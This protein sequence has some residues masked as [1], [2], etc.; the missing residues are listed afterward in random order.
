MLGPPG[1][2]D[3][4]LCGTG[5]TSRV[6]RAVEVRSGH[7]VALKRLHRQLL[8]SEEARARLKREFEALSRLRHPGLVAV[9]DVLVWQ[10][11]PTVVMDFIAGE[12]LDRRIAEQGPVSGAF[13]TQLAIALFEMLSAAHGAGIVHRDVKPQ[14]VRIAEDGRFHL[15]DFGSA[16]FDAASQLTAA[17]TSVGTPDY[18]APELFAGSVYDPRVDIYG[19]GAT[20][21]KALTG[22]APQ[23]ADSLTELAYRRTRE[24]VPPVRSLRPDVPQALAQVVDRCLQ[25]A[26]SDRFSSCALA[27]WALQHPQAELSFQDRRRAHP[28]C[29]HCARPIPPASAICPQCG[30]DH[31]FAYSPGS[32]H[33]ELHNVKDPER[34]ARWWS[35][36]FPERTEADHITHLCERLSALDEDSQRLLSFI[37][38]HEARRVADELEAEGVQCEVLEDQGTTGWR[39]YALSLALFMVGLVG[40]GHGLLGAEVAWHHAL[41]LALPSAG[42][43]VLER[44]LAVARGAQGLLSS[45]RYPAAIV[46][47]LRAGLT[48]GS[49]GLLGA[50]VLAPTVGAALSGAGAVGAGAAVGALVVPLGVAGV[51]GAAAA[52]V[53]WT[54]G[55]RRR[56]LPATSVPEPSALRMLRQAFSVPRALVSG[57]LRTETAVLLTASV[58]ALVPAEMLALD[59]VR[60]AVPA[61]GSLVPSLTSAPAIAPSLP[62]PV[63]SLPVSPGPVAGPTPGLTP[64]PELPGPTAPTSGPHP[65]P[66]A[67]TPT[68]GPQLN[69]PPWAVGLAGLF[70]LSSL[71]LIAYILARR[72]RVVRE[73][74]RIEARL[75]GFELGPGRSPPVQRR[76]GALGAADALASLPGHDRFLIG[77]RARAADLAHCLDEEGADRLA[78]LLARTVA[79]PSRPEVGPLD[80]IRPTDPD[81][82]LRFEF[83]ALEGELEASAAAAWWQRLSEDDS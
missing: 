60:Q 7:P 45:G 40:V 11:D 42:A 59:A 18:M 39:L 31:P 37:D 15:L 56:A 64:G 72:R 16:R 74:G 29:L 28:P 55:F 48:L 58:L 50:G 43:L 81:Q 76:P 79:D 53:A 63:T 22:G 67:A 21:Y 32:H 1:Y 69:L 5:A 13:A 3:V 62:V 68:T 80:T 25:R 34:L 35:E 61:L 54:A 20:L 57:R 17:G 77:A 14:N 6:F 19:V 33:V 4:A 70:G 10:G 83:L 66:V 71:G 9:R 8:R 82:R 36:R 26:P 46:P 47:N 30:S 38:E 12:D 52:C 51:G 73:G 2:T 65:A 23:V 44:V 78:R 24:P 41:L 49:G 75:S 27:L